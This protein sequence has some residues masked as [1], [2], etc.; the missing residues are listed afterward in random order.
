MPTTRGNLLAFDYAQFWR[1]T[2]A[3]IA[4]GQLDPDSPGTAPQTS[5]SFLLE[6]PMTCEL[7]GATFGQFKFRGGGSYE[8]SVDGG[9]ED[10]TNGTLTLSQCD[11]SLAALIMGTSLDTTTIT[12]GPTIW[13]VDNMRPSPVQGGLMLTRRIQSQ[14]TASQGIVSYITTIFPLVQMRMTQG[15]F[16]QD[17]SLNTSPVTVSITPQIGSKFPWGEAFSSTQG[18]YS[19]QGIEFNIQSD[20]PWALTAFLQDGTETDVV[21]AYKPIYTTVTDGRA[22]S[23]HTVNGVVTAPTS[24]TIATATIVKAAVG[25]ADQWSNHFYQTAFDVV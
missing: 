21:T 3:G 20:Y 24:I 18:W 15:N 13:S 19:N 10:L 12:G 16:S 22:N 11:A 4:T 6:G 2:S 1:V 9:L 7:P 25:T 8:G 23:V 17:T 5:H 14:V